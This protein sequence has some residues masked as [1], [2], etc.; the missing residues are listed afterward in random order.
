MCASVICR[1]VGHRADFSEL[2][3][4]VPVWSFKIR[5]RVWSRIWTHV[6]RVHLC[7]AVKGL[8]RSA[9][10][11]YDRRQMMVSTVSCIFRYTSPDAV[12]PQTCHVCPYWH[13]YAPHA[14]LQAPALALMV[15][16]RP[17]FRNHAASLVNTNVTVINDEYTK[18]F[19]ECCLIQ[20]LI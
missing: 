14:T 1:K 6:T 3:F 7:T 18:S 5:A 16:D 11:H 8:K 13:R 19:T 17:P 4:S 9:W 20:S 10:S 2:H 12:F 15:V